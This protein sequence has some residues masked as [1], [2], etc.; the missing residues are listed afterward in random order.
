MNL[1]MCQVYRAKRREL[2]FGASIFSVKWDER[3]LLSIGGFNMGLKI[4]NYSWSN[5]PSLPFGYVKLFISRLPITPGV[6]K[7]VLVYAYCPGIIIR[8]IH[9]LS[10]MSQL[11]Q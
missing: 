5:C 11:E 7:T 6:S 9:S 1:G 4:W 10:T 8:S 2:S 3:C